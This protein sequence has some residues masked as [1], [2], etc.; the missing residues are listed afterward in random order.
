MSKLWKQFIFTGVAGL[1]IAAGIADHGWSESKK[2][3]NAN[4][5]N[6]HQRIDFGN[7]YIMGQSIKSGAVYLLHRKQSD[8]NSM[9]QYRED[10]R[11]E[12]LENFKVRED[13]KEDS[14][15]KARNSK[16]F[17]K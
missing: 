2:N 5:S 16:V 10:Y 17:R 4:S 12:I 3:R 6:L 14:H 9:L 8:I 15:A 13:I 7:A 1:L 11:Q